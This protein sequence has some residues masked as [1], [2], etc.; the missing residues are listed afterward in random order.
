MVSGVWLIL[1][2]AD[3]VKPPSVDIEKAILVYWKLLK[4]AS[5]QTVYRLPLAGSM[6]TSKDQLWASMPMPP[7]GLGTPRAP[8]MFSVSFSG[9]MSAAGVGES[10]QVCPWSDERMRDS[11]K[12]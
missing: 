3:H 5:C 1:I 4:R 6:A 9:R 10:C 12:S 11:L 8:G 7:S 2:G